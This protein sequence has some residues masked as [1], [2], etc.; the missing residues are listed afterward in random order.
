MLR[1]TDP[2]LRMVAAST[3]DRMR[4][5]E[6]PAR[7]I[8]S[9]PKMPRLDG[10]GAWL[11]CRARSWQV[12]LL[13][14]LLLALPRWLLSDQLAYPAL[15]GDDFA[16]VAGSRDWPR[17]LSNLFKPH[18]T[19]IVPL[20]RLWTFA[21]VEISGRLSRLPEALSWGSYITFAI[22]LS[23]VGQ[24][25][26]RAT[27]RPAAG[28]AAIATLG[29]STVTEPVIVWYSASQALCA[30]S[31]IVAS[32]IGAGLLGVRGTSLAAG[33]RCRQCNRGAP[34]LVGRPARGAHRGRL[35][36]DSRQAQRSSSGRRHPVAR[37][38]P[39]R[40]AGSLS[41]P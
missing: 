9:S 2:L 33:A 1:R 37:W 22:A 20:F 11:D 24:M 8:G 3:A 13:V 31:A 15:S 27:N 19:H 21:L 6:P 7:A 18:N 17:T 25:V 16:F 29:L 23:L 12:V 10:V 41:Q 32:L 34:H 26:Y 5:M 14:F 38:L 35:L 40:A 30:G 39:G 28:L 4:H 36:V